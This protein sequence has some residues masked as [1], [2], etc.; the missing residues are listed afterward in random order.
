MW[1]LKKKFTLF[2]S[3]QIITAVSI[4][5]LVSYIYF[6]NTLVAKY[7]DT[8]TQTVNKIAD[9]I[10]SYVNDIDKMGLA[11]H[12]TREIGDFFN[13]RFTPIKD[14][15]TVKQQIQAYINALI[16]MKQ[17]VEGINLMR[18]DSQYIASSYEGE[19]WYQIIDSSGDK[20]TECKALVSG[21][22]FT[23]TTRKREDTNDNIILY[24]RRFMNLNLKG[25]D[26]GIIVIN[27]KSNI[28]DNFLS[29]ITKSSIGKIYIINNENTILYSGEKININRKINNVENIALSSLDRPAGSDL[30]FS[31]DGSKNLVTY[32]KSDKTG[33]TVISMIS[34][35][36]LVMNLDKMRDTIIIIGLIL[37]AVSSLVAYFISFKITNPL[38]ML[39]AQMEKVR[40]GNFDEVRINTVPGGE[41]GQLTSAFIEMV[42]DIQGLI[43]QVMEEQK[44][45]RHAEFK[46]LQSQIN[47]HFLNNTLSSLIWMVL[48]DRKQESVDIISSLANLMKNSF[49]DDHEIIPVKRELEHL[50]NYVEIQRIR[51]KSKLHV[52]FDIDESALD[53]LMP[54]FLLQPL[55]ENSILHGISLKK[56]GGI[57]KIVAKKKDNALVF[58]VIDNGMGMSLK[59][60]RTI[61]DSNPVDKKSYGVYNVNNR[62]KLHYGEMYGLN[63]S[64]KPAKGTLVVLCIPLDNAGGVEYV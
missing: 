63:F 9:D 39:S 14:Q 28:F 38:K 13:E 19:R 61:L 21:N 16:D 4:T 47:P 11:F 1:T 52:R 6:Y 42:V 48:S 55:V 45:K 41:I 30:L 49:E 33:W 3:I 57:I 62:V 34:W 18:N 29:H 32:K 35:N 27:I 44:L 20:L 36:S 54:K 7:K 53:Y 17:G 46:A 22:G 10:D 37:I 24:A 31:E 58:K 15:K 5:L 40:E 59:T 56:S 8:A 43:S 23:F 25:K 26:L 50:M 51:Y 2:A 64:S 12:Y 60:L